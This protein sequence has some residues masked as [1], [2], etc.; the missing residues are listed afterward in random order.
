MPICIYLEVQSEITH[1]Q[2]RIQRQGEGRHY[3]DVATSQKI[4]GIYANLKEAG[5]DSHH[6]I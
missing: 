1:T 4:T 3:N 2:R 6:Q 5:I